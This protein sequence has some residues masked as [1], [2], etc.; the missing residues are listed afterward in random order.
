[1]CAHGQSTFFTYTRAAKR[2]CQPGCAAGASAASRAT[3]PPD[4]RRG[5]IRNGGIERHRVGPV[6]SLCRDPTAAA[7]EHSA[8]DSNPCGRKQRGG[9]HQAPRP[10]QHLI[11][12]HQAPLP[13]IRS[14]TLTSLENA[15][16]IY[17]RCGDLIRAVSSLH[18]CVLCKGECNHLVSKSETAFEHQGLLDLKC[19]LQMSVSGSLNHTWLHHLCCPTAAT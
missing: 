3:S 4:A 11:T 6:I 19:I 15:L 16:A 8:G 9:C 13:R 1:M 5:A 2:G 18:C 17:E 7:T 10:N 14:V 12:H